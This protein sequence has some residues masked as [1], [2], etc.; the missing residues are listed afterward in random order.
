MMVPPMGQT[1]PDD[2]ETR[3]EMGQEWYDIIKKVW[4]EEER[5][6]WDGKYFKLKGAYGQP[7]AGRRD[8]GGAG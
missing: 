7:R 3:Y 4:Y 2:H 6:D 1:L 8:A 5:F